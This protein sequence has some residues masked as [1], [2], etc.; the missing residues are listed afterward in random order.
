MSSQRME[1]IDFVRKNPTLWIVIFVVVYG[2][3]FGGIVYLGVRDVLWQGVTSIGVAV[4]AVSICLMY[5][6]GFV[7]GLFY[8][9]ASHYRFQFTDEGM[10]VL[11][12][13][14]R[15]FF[16]WRD[17]R[18]ARLSIVE[19]GADLALDFGGL[20][21]VNIPIFSYRKTRTLVD[22]IARRIPVSIALM[23][24]PVGA[25]IRDH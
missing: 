3:I 9:I 25:E 24:S 11:T 2:L 22:E 18:R 8:F 13:R 6:V 4:E 21:E 19:Y 16:L 1:D 15:Q 14:G 5:L 7:A 10:N 23:D 12:W 20:R 17:V